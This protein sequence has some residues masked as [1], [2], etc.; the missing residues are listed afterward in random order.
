MIYIISNSPEALNTIPLKISP[1]L[2]LDCC[3]FNSGLPTVRFNIIQIQ[4]GG[5]AVIETRARI[6]P[7]IANIYYDPCIFPKAEQT[8]WNQCYPDT[9]HGGYIGVYDRDFGQVLLAALT[10]ELG[11]TGDLVGKWKWGM[12]LLSFG[13]S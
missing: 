9:W 13:I 8:N 7:L 2:A 11:N 4:Y 6:R 5:R 3:W 12:V 10:F 1:R